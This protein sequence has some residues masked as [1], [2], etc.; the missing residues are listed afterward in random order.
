MNYTVDELLELANGKSLLYDTKRE[1]LVFRP[2]EFVSDE[3]VGRLSFKVVSNEFL[4]KH[5]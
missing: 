4:L 1:G 3:E 2:L 5:E